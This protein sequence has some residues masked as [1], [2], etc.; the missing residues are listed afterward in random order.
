M[1]PQQLAALIDLAETTLQL[2]ESLLRL[3]DKRRQHA[4]WLQT[5]NACKQVE[6]NLLNLCRQ[7]YAATKA[8][9]GEDRVVG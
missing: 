2:N 3:I 4:R 9:D 1:T 6:G 7:Y 5:V 8:G